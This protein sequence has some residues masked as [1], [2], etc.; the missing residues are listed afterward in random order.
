[1][2]IADFRVAA[3]LSAAVAVASAQA[4]TYT[5]NTTTDAVDATPGNGICASAAGKC[6]LRAAIQE[7]NAHAGPDAVSLPAGIYVLSLVGTGDDV[8]ATGDLDVTGEL[9][10]NGA[11][12]DTTIVD[13]LRADRVLQAM[14]VFALRDVTIRNGLGTPGGGLLMVGPGK[15]DIE[16]VTFHDNLASDAGGMLHVSP[17]PLTVTAST[18]EDNATSGGDGAALLVAGPAPV[19]ISDSAFDGNLA[20]TGDGGVYLA[21][22]GAVSITNS[23][24]TNNLATNGGGLMAT[25]FSSITVSGSTFDANVADTAAAMLVAGATP[26]A[27]TNT[28][29]TNNTAA[30]MG[31]AYVIGDT[32]TVTGGEASDNLGLGSFGGYFITSNNAATI[33]GAAARRNNGGSAPGG[34]MYVVVGT[35]SLTISNVEVSENTSGSGAGLYATAGAGNIAMTKLRVLN[36][37]SGVGPAGGLLAL[38]SGTVTLVDSTVSGNISG[39]LGGGMYLAAGTDLSIQ[40]TTIAQNRSLGLAGLGGGGYV[41]AGTAMAITNSTISGNLADA[42]AGGLYIAG[43]ATIRNAT[44]VDNDSPA[45]SAI[46]NPGGAITVTSSI[47]AGSAAGHCGGAAVSSGGN[48]LDSNGSC[49]FAGSGDQN[50]VDPQLGPLADNGGPT[51]THVPAT[52]SPVLDKGAAAGCPATDQRGEARPTDADGDG[53]PVCDIGAVEFLDLCPSDPAKVM[54]GVCGCGVPEPGLCGCG[55]PDTDTGQPNGTLDCFI[56]GELKARVARAKA[57]IGSLSGDQ[58]PNEAELD[59]IGQSLL[60]YLTQ[61]HGQVAMNGVEKKVLKL[62]KRASKAIA[63]V[64]KA[65]GKKIEKAKKKANK[66]L[67]KF[68]VTIAPQ[69]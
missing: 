62:A 29:M 1:M 43:N 11:G 66:A 20:Y 34:G 60:P 63:K 2:R 54:P 18:F 51:R 4:D 7:A 28:V 69:A 39:S 35:G 12:A 58:D 33:D 55:I 45:G 50:N 37:G 9:Q 24:F 32:V 42:T 64:T 31:G 49:A 27:L 46:F 21:T 13:G 38:A 3:L 8:A 19:T 30:A 26:V 61:Y 16:R 41:A 67:D 25:G 14:A 36:N 5:V 40:G 57:I 23:T 17:D 47:I 6:T 65:K 59:A 48:N 44:F 10:L 22:T 53:T 15:C 52:G 68:D 56:N